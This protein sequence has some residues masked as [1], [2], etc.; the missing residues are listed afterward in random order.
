MTVGSLDHPEDI[1]PAGH[2]G[3]ESRVAWANIGVGLPEE[4]T[5]EEF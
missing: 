3:V 1:R 5:K 2:Y 4:Q